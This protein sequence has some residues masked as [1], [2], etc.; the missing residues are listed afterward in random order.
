MVSSNQ[1]TELE[2]LKE[3]IEDGLSTIEAYERVDLDQMTLE[4]HLVLAEKIRI[5]LQLVGEINEAA[6]VD[7]S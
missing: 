5:V 3:G 2:Q 1:L 7:Y 6:G 4:G